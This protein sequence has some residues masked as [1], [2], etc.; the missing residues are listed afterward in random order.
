MGPSKADCASA[1]EANTARKPARSPMET[2]A[3]IAARA[4]GPIVPERAVTSRDRRHS[5][6]GVPGKQFVIVAS[7]PEHRGL[8]RRAFIARAAALAVP[9]QLSACARAPLNVP[10]YPFPL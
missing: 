1:S 7:V 3:T 9:S 2:K 8:T 4:G 5:F 10:K 6:G